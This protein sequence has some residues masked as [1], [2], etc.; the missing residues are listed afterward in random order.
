MFYTCT[1]HAYKINKKKLYILCTRVLHFKKL[2]QN[3]VSS[4]SLKRESIAHSKKFVSTSTLFIV[5]KHDARFLVSDAV[6]YGRSARKFQ[7][8]KRK[9]TSL[10][11]LATLQKQLRRQ[12]GLRK[13]AMAKVSGSARLCSP[14]PSHS[15]RTTNFPRAVRDYGYVDYESANQTF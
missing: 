13:M 4:I 15:S 9:Y 8:F 1:V 5:R 2:Y 10:H 7:N 6:Q 12:N 3:Y 14:P 11:A